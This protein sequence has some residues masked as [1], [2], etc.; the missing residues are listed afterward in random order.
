MSERI[1]RTRGNFFL[2]IPENITIADL[3]L[4]PSTETVA[5]EYGY[6]QVYEETTSKIFPSHTRYT[7]IYV[8]IV[9]DTSVYLIWI[10]FTFH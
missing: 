8:S 3:Q 10:T 9:G 7:Y 4:T 6:L 5:K 1:S 2:V